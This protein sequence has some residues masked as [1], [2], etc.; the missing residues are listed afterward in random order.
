MKIVDHWLQADTP[1]EKSTRIPFAKRP[2]SH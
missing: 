2:A 1:Q